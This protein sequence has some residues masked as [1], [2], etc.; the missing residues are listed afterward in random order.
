MVFVCL[1]VCFSLDTQLFY[2]SFLLRYIRVWGVCLC[3]L[4]VDSFWPWHWGA[5]GSRTLSIAFPC[6]SWVTNCL[7]EQGHDPSGLPD[8]CLRQGPLELKDL[9]GSRE[10]VTAATPPPRAVQTPSWYPLPKAANPSL[11]GQASLQPSCCCDR[12]P[13]AFG[14]VGFRPCCPPAPSQNLS[15]AW[16]GG[17]SLPSTGFEY[18]SRNKTLKL[19]LAA[20]GLLHAPLEALVRLCFELPRSPSEFITERNIRLCIKSKLSLGPHRW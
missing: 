16:G 3:L 13:C 4:G 8:G 5:G 19:K 11:V 18:C 2:L 10:D 7:L 20:L 12:Y 1:F 15:L 9:R 6:S 14:E 17:P